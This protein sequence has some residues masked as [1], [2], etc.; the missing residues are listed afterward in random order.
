MKSE[1]SYSLKAIGFF[2]L[3]IYLFSLLDSSFF[4]L[5]SSLNLFL[6]RHFHAVQQGFLT[7]NYYLSI[8]VNT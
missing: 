4:T 1:E 3:C 5:C 8:V 7:G 6:Y 2:V